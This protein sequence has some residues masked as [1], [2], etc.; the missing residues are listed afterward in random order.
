VAE[1][2]TPHLTSPLWSFR[3]AGRHLSERAASGM[4]N[5]QHLDQVNAA[6]RPYA[7]PSAALKAGIGE[8]P[9]RWIC[10]D[11]RIRVCTK[12]FTSPDYFEKLMLSNPLIK[13]KI[14]INV[15]VNSYWTKFSIQ[16][17]FKTWR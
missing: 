10:N 11:Q 17:I 7:A 2:I 6:G 13:I 1:A 15:S 9:V 5:N 16:A 12:V 4:L 8:P 14:T 3:R